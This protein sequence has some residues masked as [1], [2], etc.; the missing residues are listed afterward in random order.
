MMTGIQVLQAPM[1][2]ATPTTT[3]QVPQQPMT[4]FIIQGQFGQQLLQVNVLELNFY[5]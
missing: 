5:V 2:A 3:P 4:G 1:A